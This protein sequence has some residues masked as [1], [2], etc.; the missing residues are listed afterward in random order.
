MKKII[1]FYILLAFLSSCEDFL[2]LSDPSSLTSG[3]F[4]KDA[5]QVEQAINGIYGRLQPLMHQQWTFNELISDNT[6]VQMN[7][8]SLGY[9]NR[10]EAFDF[11]V[12]EPSNFDLITMYDN[13]YYSVHNINFTLNKMEGADLTDSERNRF[14][15]EL[16]FLR[17]YHYYNL[18]NYFGPV[19]LLTEP[20]L[21][22]EESFNVTR[23]D[24]D[25]VYAQ[26]ID[27][28]TDASIKLPG[29]SE[30]P[31]SELGRATKGAA[32]SLLGKVYLTLKDYGNAQS[33]LTQVTSLGYSLV[34]DYASVFDPQNKNN[35]E[36]IFEVQY[37]G[38]NTLGEHSSFI[39]RFAPWNSE[40]FI[41]GDPTSSPA[42]W[43]M[44]T[45]SIMEDFE[46]GDLRKDVSFK[47]GFFNSENEWIPVQYINKFSDQG[48][49]AGQTNDNWPILRYSD[50]LLMLAEAINE[51]SGPNSSAYDYL[52][53]VRER[54]GLELM[55][56]L[57]KESFRE[58]VLK[59]RRVEL[60]FENHRWF[61]LKRTMS[62]SELVAYLNEYG[63]DEIANPSISRSGILQKENDYK[64][65]E[66]EL[67][68][69]LP[70]KQVTL[71]NNLIQQN[72]GY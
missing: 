35:S 40:G 61:D 24:E 21:S 60:A 5:S 69:P 1:I 45:R 63:A 16:K 4:Y 30:Y 15:G 28:L 38:G 3:S 44:P 22:P 13:V 65:A 9:S 12:V 18:V 32:L 57:N 56:G 11:W 59:E 52:N 51:Q 17:A 2:D 48:T 6:C 43:N 66:Y 14:I 8:G 64:I 47:T 27:D 62:K 19:V 25:A 53:K 46:D 37:L 26:I 55:D 29:K 20:L 34:Q 68:F 71:S 70:E 41:T 49:I 67:I 33:A 39:Y 50:V 72:P 31:G 36:S 54:A 58:A 42:G 10:H 7:P 23:S